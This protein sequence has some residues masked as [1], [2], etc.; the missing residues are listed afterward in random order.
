MTSGTESGRSLAGE[1]GV[2][3]LTDFQEREGGVSPD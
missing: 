3:F 2:I 1:G